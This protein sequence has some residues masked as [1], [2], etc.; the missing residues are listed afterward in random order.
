M[1]SI[2]GKDNPDVRVRP[3]TGEMFFTP[4]GVKGGPTVPTGRNIKDFMKGGN[5]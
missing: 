4:R 1:K 2:R 5:E 3:E